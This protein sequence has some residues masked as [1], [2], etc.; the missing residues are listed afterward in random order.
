MK[1]TLTSTTKIV[2]LKP[3]PLKDGIPARIWEGETE[4]IIK[5]HAY[6]TRVAVGKDENVE[7]FQKELRECEVPSAEIQSI[8]SRL[9][10]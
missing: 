5:V 1:L 6:I 2:M 10:L 4:T 8:P 7:Q 9:I 3:G